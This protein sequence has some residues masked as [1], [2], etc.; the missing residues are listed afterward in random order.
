MGLEF[1]CCMFWLELDYRTDVLVGVGLQVLVML[2]V[3]VLAGVKVHMDGIRV[4][5]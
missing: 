1:K 3:L 2:Q 5:V 4:L